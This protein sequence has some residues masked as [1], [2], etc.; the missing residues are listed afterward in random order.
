MKPSPLELERYFFAKVQLEANTQGDPKAGNQIQS[1]VQVGQAERDPLRY[2]VSLTLK[3]L[4]EEKGTPCYTGEFHAVG[5]FKVAEHWPEK[6]RIQLV[7]TNGAALL[8]GSLRELI[9]TLTARGPWPPVTLRSV[10]FLRAED[11]PPSK[12]KPKVAGAVRRTAGAHSK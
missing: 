11:S 5:F 4:A 8:Y 1:Q 10:T 9:I 12:A 2:Q 6:Q 3:L 7:E